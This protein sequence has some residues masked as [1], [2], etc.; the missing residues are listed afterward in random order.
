MSETLSH[1]SVQLSADTQ[2]Y[3][4]AI[5]KSQTETKKRLTKMQKDMSAT[6][7]ATKVA[8]NLMIGALSAVAGAFVISSI[9]SFITDTVHANQEMRYLAA[10][11]G[12]TTEELY[13]YDYAAKH[14]GMSAEGLTDAFKEVAE[15]MSD[16]ERGTGEAVALLD[17]L[18]LSVKDFKNLA[19]AEQYG[20]LVSQLDKLSDSDALYWADKFGDQFFMLYQRSREL[21]VSVNDLTREYEEMFGMDMSTINSAM[22]DM[23]KAMIE[24]DSMWSVFKQSFT[25]A[26]A[27]PIL[28]ALKRMKDYIKS[29]GGE[30]N[31]NLMKGM[32]VL[33]NDMI[34]SLE[35]F[36]NGMSQTFTSIYNGVMSAITEL[37]RIMNKLGLGTSYEETAGYVVTQSDISAKRQEQ[38]KIRKDLSAYSYTTQDPNDPSRVNNKARLAELDAEI[39]LLQQRDKIEREAFENRKSEGMTFNPMIAKEFD[40]SSMKVGQQIFEGSTASADSSSDTY[41]PSS[42]ANAQQKTLSDS[43]IKSVRESVMTSEQIYAEQRDNQLK[44][45]E[46]AYKDELI[47]KEAYDR[48]KLE[49]ERLYQRQVDEIGMSAADVKL[50]KDATEMEQL[51]HKQ[52]I[53]LEAL[54]E[55]L[56]EKKALEAEY[57]AAVYDMEL[58]HAEQKAALLE[59][60]RK[61][62]RSSLMQSVSDIGAQ[63]GTVF[64][65]QKEFALVTSLVNQ[66]QAIAQA[67]ADPTL[68]FYS[69]IAAS[70]TAGAAVASQIASIQSVEGQ[71]HAGGVVPQDMDNSSFR[72]K[73]GERVLT[74]EQNQKFE[75][76]ESN[77]GMMTGTTTIE[78]PLIVQGNVFDDGWFEQQAMKHR[79]TLSGVVNKSN[80]ERPRR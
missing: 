14:V 12:M 59:E 27:P 38:A 3:L 73:A 18:N 74:P 45:A 76:L 6:A 57:N 33:Y 20:E 11:V 40:L 54:K 26:V 51:A 19:P 24:I 63:L 44:S 61:T 29:L 10:Q 1:V 52:A 66:G 50:G 70:I 17:E 69:K 21:G 5:K 72:L 22:T 2:Q 64:G 7:K 46:Q 4:D 78:A 13:A 15:R 71:F 56:N 41:T 55:H 8:T 16:A 31:Q 43:W 80:S 32:S 39:A 62:E 48:A 42:S 60:Q 34:S 79:H 77:A 37:N 58:S 36:L 30:G 49:A 53:E 65:M 28:D 75:L 47:S 23:N 35:L 25:A 68:D 9:T 67:W